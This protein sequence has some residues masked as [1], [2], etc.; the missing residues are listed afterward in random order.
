MTF[1]RFSRFTLY[2]LG[3]L[4]LCL[5][6]IGIYCYQNL[7]LI[8]TQQAK[9]YLQQYGVQ[10]IR[11]QQLDVSSQQLYT[12][13]LWLRGTRDGLIFEATLEDLEL[14]YHW[15]ALLN[16]ELESVT[17]A[18]LTLA[19]DN[20]TRDNTTLGNKST[21]SPINT[22]ALLPQTLLAALPLNSLIIE[23]W[24]VNYRSPDRSPILLKGNL[25]LAEQL[26][27]QMEA[28]RLDSHLK[29]N[30]TS[31]V[32][33]EQKGPTLEA[34][35]WLHNGTSE[36]TELTE[37]TELSAQLNQAAADEW[38][39]ELQG[40]AQF[41]PIL[42]WLR[43]LNITPTLSLITDLTLRGQSQFN[44]TIKHPNSFDVPS[45]TGL[46]TTGLASLSPFDTTITISNTI[47]Q[48]DYPNVADSIAGTLNIT[49]TLNNQLLTVTIDPTELTGK[50]HTQ[51][52]SLPADTQYWLGWPK[53]IPIHWYSPE[54]IDITFNQN[55]VWSL[56][57]RN[58]LL[59][60]GNQQSELRWDKINVAIAAQLPE[61][62]NQLNS[63]LNPHL[64][65]H[66][67]YHFNSHLDSRLNSRLHKQAIPQLKL[68][69]EQQGSLDNSQF[70][71]SLND[72]AA[73]MS[74]A[75]QGQINVTSGQGQYNLSAHSLDLPYAASS[76][77]PMLNNFGLLPQSVVF[78]S[79]NMALNSTLTSQNFDLAGWQQ[80]SQLTTQHLS[81]H[82]G[83]Y[84]FEDIAATANWSGIDR[85]QTK[86]PI[87]LTINKL[88]V[89]FDLQNIQAQISLPKATPIAQPLIR[90]EQ[91]SAG[92]F[93]GRVYLAKPRNWDFAAD[94]NQLT[95][96]AEQWQLTDMI[97]LQQGQ[98][99]QGK[100]I[101]EGELPIAM[102]AGRMII[103]KGYLRAL[104][105]GGE[106]RYIANEASR[107]L[108]RTS[109]ELGQALD[110]LSNFQYEV[111]SSEVSLDKQGNLL[112]G[113]SLSGKNPE[114]Y[115]GRPVNF[116]INIEQNLDPLLQ[117]LRLSDK[118]EEQIEDRLR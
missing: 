38:R 78:T 12:N 101:L 20:T 49:A 84:Q 86:Q 46:T 99:I 35:F 34:V 33:G 22:S 27:L 114:K 26:H 96:H 91:F 80:Q 36:L 64:N 10:D 94:T 108:A 65:P 115:E 40:K 25:Q 106:I 90:I 50:L 111:L 4:L 69:L 118:L 39:W 87:Q 5:L 11:L 85:W 82:Y 117:S 44:A 41:G 72:I 73:S 18:N 24:Q 92:I 8:V 59:T 43:Q 74:M 30:I 53:T 15:R 109:P 102:A 81:G 47:E 62:A 61:A 104:A 1:A 98:D 13:K 112:L 17:L 100:G 23:Q 37:L 79:G 3:L 29:A 58:S 116:N 89:G 68:S 75:L 21:T 6:G 110:L 70:N 66:L 97:A 14:N 16:G 88:D 55:D 107:E 54:P 2:G 57:L 103:N 56:K 7:S 45:A 67:N 32:R 76:L 95:L 63:Q 113:L 48:L 93:G 51:Q 77:M 105:P 31:H 19:I 71:L 42:A 9:V 28:S 60:L 52:L 83:E